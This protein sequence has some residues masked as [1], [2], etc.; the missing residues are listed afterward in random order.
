MH[1]P[2]PLGCSG[3]TGAAPTVATAAAA[4]SLSNCPCQ[5]AATCRRAWLCRRWQCQPVRMR[6]RMHTA[7]PGQDSHHLPPLITHHT[8]QQ[9][10]GQ[11]RNVLF[12]PIIT[13]QDLQQEQERQAGRRGGHMRDRC[14]CKAPHAPCT[15]HIR[16]SFKQ[17]SRRAYNEGEQSG[18]CALS[19]SCCSTQLLLTPAALAAHT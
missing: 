9:L 2:H 16:D 15:V 1:T 18:S 8:H 5:H 11:V 7:W 4:A 3:C 17:A 10:L 19:S 14:F 6:V 12:R 13:A